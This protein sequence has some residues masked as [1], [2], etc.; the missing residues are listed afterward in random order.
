MKAQ[1][2]GA[3]AVVGMVANHLRAD[4][5]R[6]AARQRWRNSMSDIAAKAEARALAPAWWEQEG[7]GR[8]A[9]RA[10]IRER[11]Q[12]ARRDAHAWHGQT[13][14]GEVQGSSDSGAHR[15]GHGS[16]GGTEGGEG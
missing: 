8:T 1:E 2:A 3:L 4:D 5:A 12:Q 15:E 13:R 14:F 10:A 16:S 7:A 6:M 11:E 9:R